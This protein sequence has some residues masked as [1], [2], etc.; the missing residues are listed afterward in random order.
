MSLIIKNCTIAQSTRRHCSRRT[1]PE[2]RRRHN[3]KSHY[4]DK[5]VRRADTAE[6]RIS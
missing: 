5:N 1:L 3:A 6:N 2:N 4:S